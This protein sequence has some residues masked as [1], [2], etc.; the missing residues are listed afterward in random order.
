MG[1]GII[2][3]GMCNTADMRIEHI[4]IPVANDFLDHYGHLFRLYPVI[5]CLDIALGNRGVDGG[6]Y[7][8][9]CIHQLVQP[10]IGIGM[11]IWYKVSL[12]DPCKGLVERILKE[13]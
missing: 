7:E 6:V 10:H 5:H 3:I 2:I 12:E 8:L 9:D 11:I 4:P 13:P 1:K